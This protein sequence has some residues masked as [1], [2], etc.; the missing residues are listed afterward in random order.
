MNSKKYENILNILYSIY[1]L[2][3]KF[4]TFLLKGSSIL[5][6]NNV[7]YALNLESYW[8]SIKSA[9]IESGFLQSTNSGFCNIL[10]QSNCSLSPTKIYSNLIDCMD[11]NASETWSF[12]KGRYSI[13]N[14]LNVWDIFYNK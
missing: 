9:F 4:V 11:I 5:N 1:L 2:V 8:F 12:V 14:F 10:F 6:K 13:P 7:F 3:K